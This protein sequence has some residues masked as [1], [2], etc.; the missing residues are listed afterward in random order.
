MR[1]VIFAGIATGAAIGIGLA[2]LSAG[3]PRSTTE[4]GAPSPPT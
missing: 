2:L 4:R 1:N 3:S